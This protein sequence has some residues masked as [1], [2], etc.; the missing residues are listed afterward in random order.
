[1]NSWNKINIEVIDLR[2]YQGTYLVLYD[3]I[4][5]TLA[6]KHNIANHMQV[7]SARSMGASFD[8]NISERLTC[9]RK[10]FEIAKTTKLYKSKIVA[11][12]H[13]NKSVELWSVPK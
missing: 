2:K 12:V 8:L 1:M 11:L 6:K 4:A 5:K 13:F 10:L 3:S 9:C 7:V